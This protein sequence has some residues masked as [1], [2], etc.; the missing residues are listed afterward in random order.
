[1]FGGL[2][3]I[4]ELPRGPFDA[5]LRAHYS[6]RPSTLPRFSM[7]CGAIFMIERVR[8]LDTSLSPRGALAETDPLLLEEMITLVAARG[9]DVVSPG[10][11]RRRL[12]ERDL[13]RRF[14]V[15]SFDGAYRSILDTV[16]PLFERRAMPFAVYAGSDYLDCG[17]V[18]WWLA[19]E[20]LVEG[21]ER[22]SIEIG[23]EKHDHRCRSSREKQDVYA[24]LFR[25]L[26]K[27]EP[28]KR[29]MQLEKASAKHGPDIAAVAQREML[30]AEELKRLAGNQLVTV[31]SQAGGMQPLSELSFDGAQD[32][33]AVS[34]AALEVA[35]GERPRHLAF[36]GGAK[37]N[38]TVRDVKIAQ[39]MGLETA[40]TGIE[41]ALWPEHAR[42]LLALPRIALDNDPATLVRALM[43][44]GGAA[45]PHAALA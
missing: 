4:R 30:G 28:G 18:P 1:M 20:A 15:F 17:R 24:Q 3:V 21:N 39:E 10:E 22:V 5:Y 33:L 32:A 11:M 41:G 6:D 26:A 34:L 25:S 31:G 2:T 29:Q 38:V 44:G 19:L 9:L 42:E 14:I 16:L 23:E 27:Q 36:P 13:G 35:T 37:A 45:S 7:G 8:P 40:M 12:L 43:L